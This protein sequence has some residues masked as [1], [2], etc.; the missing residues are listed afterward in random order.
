MKVSRGTRVNG[1]A[2]YTDTLV[3]TEILE[4]AFQPAGLNNGDLSQ[5]GFGWML[6]SH[7][8]WGKM[9]LHTG[10]NPGY[11]SIIIRLIDVHRTVILLNNNQHKN[12]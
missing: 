11:R 5:Y 9:V 4:E 7:P 6:S 2:L 8:T 10:D 1:A 12:F 3:K